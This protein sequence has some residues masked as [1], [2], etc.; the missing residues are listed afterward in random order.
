MKEAT[1]E[2]NDIFGTNWAY[3]IS[4][5]WNLGQA[6]REG[7]NFFLCFIA[8]KMSFLFILLSNKNDAFQDWNL[9][10]AYS[11]SKQGRH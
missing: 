9:H 4:P 6:Q 10:N 7:T 8:K 2:R 1:D 11:N 3:K 5:F